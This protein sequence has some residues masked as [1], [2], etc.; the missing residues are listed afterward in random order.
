MQIIMMDNLWGNMAKG[1]FS[2][3][4]WRTSYDFLIL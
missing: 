3:W 4:N 2:K 1:N